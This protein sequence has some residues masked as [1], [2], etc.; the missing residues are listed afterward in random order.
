MADG[1]MLLN[2]KLADVLSTKAL[3]YTVIVPF[4]AFFGA[5]GFVLEPLINYFHLTALADKLLAVLGLRFLG[6][7][8][9]MRIWSFCL[10]YVMAELWASVVISVLFW[11]F[12]NQMSRRD[13]ERRR[14]DS[15]ASQRDASKRSI[16]HPLTDDA[17]GVI[18]MI[19][20][21]YLKATGCKKGRVFSIDPREFT[22]L[23]E[24]NAV[25]TAC[26][27][28]LLWQQYQC[29]NNPLDRPPHQSLVIYRLLLARLLDSCLLTWMFT[30]FC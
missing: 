16:I 17:I 18:G 1:F 20:D 7:V 15:D 12:A 19:S 24:S 21:A 28:Q 22:E 9:I 8:A 13:S 11:G 5:F 23:K 30:T 2:S 3:F 4:I 27:C 6:P 25:L 29:D 10:F 26:S 14:G